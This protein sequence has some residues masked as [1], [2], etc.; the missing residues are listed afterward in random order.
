MN[1]SGED[2]KKIK[3]EST[4]VKSE[5]LKVGSNFSWKILPVLN[6]FADVVSEGVYVSASKVYELM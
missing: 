5:F 3:C 1:F 6:V 4:A 2:L